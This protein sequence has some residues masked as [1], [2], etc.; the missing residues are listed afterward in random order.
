[1]KFDEDFA[2]KALTAM[3]QAVNKALQKKQKLGQYAVIYADKKVQ[4]IEAKDIKVH[5]Q[6]DNKPES[7]PNGTP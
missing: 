3:K 5:N 7:S 6:E 4:R 1:M 2:Q